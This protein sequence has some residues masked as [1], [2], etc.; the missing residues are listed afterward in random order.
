M[1]NYCSNWIKISGSIQSITLLKSQSF[2]LQTYY[3]MPNNLN[4]EDKYEWIENNWGS[5]WI[6]NNDFS[7]NIY[8]NYNKNNEIVTE[9]ISAWSPPISFYIHLVNIIP[10]IIIEYEYYEYMMTFAGYGLISLDK[11]NNI[12]EHLTYENEEELNVI[13]NL[14]DWNLD[15]RNNYFTLL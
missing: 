1:P 8:F 7:D 3:P 4:F 13:I 12:Y 10:D 5:K 9:F 11:N 6:L 14:R 2:N 15:I